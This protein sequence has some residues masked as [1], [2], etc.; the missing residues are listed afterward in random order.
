M[1][2]ILRKFPVKVV[3]DAFEEF[4]REWLAGFIRQIL[5][6]MGESF[7]V[8]AQ[9]EVALVAPGNHDTLRGFESVHLVRL[10][11]ELF[12]VTECG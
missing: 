7:E 12:L 9:E 8:G 10:G 5:G 1:V 11:F 2:G 3:F 4:L 6:G